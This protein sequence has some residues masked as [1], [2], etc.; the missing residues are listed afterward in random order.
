MRRLKTGIRP[1]LFKRD[2]RPSKAFAKSLEGKSSSHR[3]WLLKLQASISCK[4]RVASS[5]GTF[6]LTEFPHQ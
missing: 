4:S 3:V 5:L 1:M 6:Q 2:I